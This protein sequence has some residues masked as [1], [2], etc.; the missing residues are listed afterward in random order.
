MATETRYFSDELRAQPDYMSYQQSLPDTTSADGNRGPSAVGSVQGALEVVARVYET[1]ALTGTLTIKLQE[2][3]TE[4]G[5]YTDV[6]DATVTI[7][8]PAQAPGVE[9]ARFALNRNSK[10]YIKA[11]IT[12]TATPTGG[13]VNIYPAHVS[14]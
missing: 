2:S 7:T 13:K 4:G 12:T 9:L 10:V 1:L 3:D 14:R 8:N 5:T 11:V 6:V